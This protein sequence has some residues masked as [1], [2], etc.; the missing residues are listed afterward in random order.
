MTTPPDETIIGLIHSLNC[1]YCRNLMP[2]WLKMKDNIHKKYGEKSPVF[3]EFEANDLEKL[4]EYNKKNKD[5]MNGGTISYSGFPTIFKISGGNIEYYKNDAERDAT[6][7]E[8]WFLSIKGGKKYTRKSQKHR[9]REKQTKIKKRK[10]EKTK[11][12]KTQKKHK[13]QKRRKPK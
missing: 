11:R 10:Q 13:T 3:L 9:K 6:T 2:E 12:R 5:K 1:I 8:H 7:M 4:E